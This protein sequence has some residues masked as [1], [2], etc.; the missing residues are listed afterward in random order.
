MSTFVPPPGIVT[1]WSFRPAPVC[2]CGRP[3]GPDR[4]RCAI[5][6]EPTPVYDALVEGV[7]RATIALTPMGAHEGLMRVEGADPD[8]PEYRAGCICGWW[9]S[10]PTDHGLAR[11]LVDDH[12]ERN[13][14]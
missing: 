1:S 6:A 12:V 3:Y 10:R 7:G 14:S 13:A 2:S 11:A 4:D 8:R 5:C 9:A